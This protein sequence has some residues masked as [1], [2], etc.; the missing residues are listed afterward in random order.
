MGH[1]VFGPKG[2][3]GAV[4]PEGEKGP[5]GNPGKAVG[6]VI[7]KHKKG[8]NNI[9]VFRKTRLKSKLSFPDLK[10]EFLRTILSYCK[11]VNY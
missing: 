4:G 2:D 1:S 8:N 7:I 6:S 11:P 9:A 10:L 3:V 5:P